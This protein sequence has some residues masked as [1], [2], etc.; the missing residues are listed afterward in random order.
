MRLRNVVRHPV[1]DLSDRCRHVGVGERTKLRVSD[2]RNAPIVLNE[3]PPDLPRRPVAAPVVRLVMDGAAGH[4]H[5]QVRLRVAR[6]YYLQP[7]KFP[8]MPDKPEPRSQKAAVPHIHL[9]DAQIDPGMNIVIAAHQ[10]ESHRGR[11]RNPCR[12]GTASIRDRQ[13][14]NIHW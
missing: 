13:A 14:P 10:V 9:I 3:R 7:V 11:Y 5:Q 4:A 12:P 8:N 1:V 2:G 6:S